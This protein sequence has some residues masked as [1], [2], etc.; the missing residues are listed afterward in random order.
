[1]HLVS[2]TLPNALTARRLADGLVRA[3]LVACVSYWSIRSTF[4]WKGKLHHARE[5]L[6]EAKTAQPKSV[7]AWLEKNHRYGLPVI[8][9]I[10]ASAN[11]LGERWVKNESKPMA[12]PTVNRPGSKSKTR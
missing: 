6:L 4:H 2:T 7:M 12:H 1:M 3:H 9:S 11:A 5:I 10:R 8:T